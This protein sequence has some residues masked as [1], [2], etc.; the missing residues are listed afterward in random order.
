MLSF[1][2]FFYRFFARIYNVKHLYY[3]I[4]PYFYVKSSIFTTL[5][6]SLLY[7][8]YKKY[9]PKFALERIAIN[10]KYMENI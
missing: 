10:G 7:N 1:L 3:F 5:T 2:D 4:I 9:A 6:L 8:V